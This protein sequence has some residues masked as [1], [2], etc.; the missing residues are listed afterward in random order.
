VSAVITCPTCNRQ[1][2]IVGEGTFSCP[3]GQRIEVAGPIASRP[4]PDKRFECPT[5]HAMMSVNGFGVFACPMCDQ[6]VRV[7]KESIPGPNR[8]GKIKHTEFIGVG[9]AV[10]VLGIALL[11]LFPIGTII[12]IALLVWGS[13]LSVKW[14]CATCGNRI[15]QSAKICPTCKEHIA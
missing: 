1:L 5:C 4:I 3:C 12:G 2:A 8:R 15:E 6:R 9:C 7:T 14:Q 13:Q 11:F 10:Q